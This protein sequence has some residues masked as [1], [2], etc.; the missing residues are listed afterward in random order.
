MSVVYL[1]VEV[2]NSIFKFQSALVAIRHKEQR[3]FKIVVCFSFSI[4]YVGMVGL[5]SISTFELDSV[6]LL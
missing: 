3:N 4:D 6:S 2:L 1:Y 5:T